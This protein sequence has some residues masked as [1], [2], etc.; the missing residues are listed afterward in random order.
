MNPAALLVLL[1]ACAMILL[2]GIGL[3]IVAGCSVPRRRNPSANHPAN[4]GLVRLELDN[5]EG[6]FTPSNPCTPIWPGS[7]LADQVWEDFVAEVWPPRS[8]ETD[9]TGPQ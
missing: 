4:R 6:R 8:L 1:L 2:G 5:T 9:G 3:A 7:A